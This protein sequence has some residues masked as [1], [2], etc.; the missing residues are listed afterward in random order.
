MA[1]VVRVDEKSVFCLEDRKIRLSGKSDGTAPG[2]T[3]DGPERMA[4]QD[5]RL[6]SRGVGEA[7]IG[8]GENP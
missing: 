4:P 1:D 6:W 3:G 5:R 8:R 7:G 2:T